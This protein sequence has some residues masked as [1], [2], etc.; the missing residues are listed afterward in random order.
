[1][2]RGRV[3]GMVRPVGRLLEDRFKVD[4]C[5]MGS[6]LSESCSV[7]EIANETDGDEAGRNCGGRKASRRTFLFCFQAQSGGLNI[8]Q[9]GLKVDTV[10]S[11]ARI[12]ATSLQPSATAS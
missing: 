4:G 10:G 3:G 8:P 9:L 2:K 1:M 6:S 5:A 7:A 11:P 12:L